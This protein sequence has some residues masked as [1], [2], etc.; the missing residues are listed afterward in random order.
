MR[1]GP[2]TE[3][4][5]LK[6]GLKKGTSVTVYTEVDCWY[7]L[8]LNADNSFGYIHKD[9]V[10]LNGQ[11]DAA[12]TPEP[13]VPVGMVRGVLR[14]TVVLRESPSLDDP[15]KIKEFY[16]DQVVY[17]EFKEGDFYYVHVAGTNYKGYMMASLIKASDPMPEKPG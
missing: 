7:F 1:Q 2:G 13:E 5:I 3:Y 16:K 11:P 8:K 15:V 17:I 14:S 10:Q 4:K 9:L 12:A 6:E